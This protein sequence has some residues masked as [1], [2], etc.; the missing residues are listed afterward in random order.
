MKFY[1]L[2]HGETT[3]YIHS[4]YDEH[5]MRLAGGMGNT[6]LKGIVLPYAL[7]LNITNK[8]EYY[9][10][11]NGGGEKKFVDFI[12]RHKELFTNIGVKL[13]DLRKS[14]EKIYK[15]IVCVMNRDKDIIESRDIGDVRLY[16]ETVSDIFQSINYLYDFET[17]G[18]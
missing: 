1:I 6:I 12:E 2:M 14:F 16:E 3:K 13:P 4:F 10:F 18:E 17:D 7:G 15:F 9:N 5:A 8:N 11:V